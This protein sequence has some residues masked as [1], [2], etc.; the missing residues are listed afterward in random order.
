[1]EPIHQSYQYLKQFTADAS[2]ELRNPIALIQTNVQVALADPQPI[3]PDQRQQLEVIERLTR[4]LGRLVDDLLFLTRQDSGMI[5]PQ[6]QPCPLDALL[7]EVIEEQT[8]IAHSKSIQLKLDIDADVN[9][10]ANSHLQGDPLT[11]S[12]DYD[13]LVRLFTNLVSNGIQYTPQGGSVKVTLQSCQRHNSPYLQVQVHDSGCGIPEE[14]LPHVFER[15]YRVDPAR[16]KQ[17]APAAAKTSMGTGLGLAIAQAIVQN[18][19]GQIRVESVPNQGTTFT[20]LLP[21]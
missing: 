11:L 1:M 8:A 5:Q 7:M 20:V 18:H 14:A 15:F 3:P 21:S 10:G 19:Q 4:R 13:Q 2:H 9:S 17:A 16:S 6:L 12:G